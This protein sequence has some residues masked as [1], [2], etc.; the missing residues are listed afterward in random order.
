MLSN[1]KLI[2]KE[3]F[4]YFKLYFYF[5]CSIDVVTDQDNL[6]NLSQGNKMKATLEMQDKEIFF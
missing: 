6:I 3:I 2:L 5:F 4:F 1:I